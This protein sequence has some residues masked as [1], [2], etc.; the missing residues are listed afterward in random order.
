MPDYPYLRGASPRDR[1]LYRFSGL[2]RR[3]R[4]P[5]GA[6][7]EGAG[8][9]P[10]GFP[11]LQAARPPRRIQTLTGATDLIAACGGL[12]WIADGV[13]YWNGVS[14]GGVS[15][16]RHQLAA[17]GSRIVIFPDKL[18]LDTAQSGTLQ[19][20]EAKYSGKIVFTSDSMTLDSPPPF[21]V[22]DG[23]TVS[24]C[25]ALAENQKTVVVREIHGNTLVCA[26]DCFTAGTASG[27]TVQRQVPAL[28]F[29]CEKDNRLW[30]VWENRICCSV[31]GD[32]CNWNVFEGLAGDGW[33]T[34]VGT[35]G[36][37]TGCAAAASHVLFFKEDCVHKVYGV[38]PS[39]FQVQVSRIPGVQAGCERSIVNVG[40]I[41]YW[42]AR[43]GLMAYGGGIPDR[44]S[45]PLGTA[46]WEQVCAGAVGHTLYLSGLRDGQPDMTALQ[47]ESGAFA[48][49]CAVCALALGAQAG[50]F[51]YLTGD[52]LWQLDGG[53]RADSCWQA[54]LGPFAQPDGTRYK[55]SRLALVAELDAGAALTAEWQADDGDWT[56][57][58]SGYGRP[59]GHIRIP[60]PLTR[61]RRAALRLTGRGGAAVR[62]IVRRTLPDGED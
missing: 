24:G 26:A 17:I 50:D 56:P 58:W 35:G 1:V 40:E 47:L 46:A 28:R 6:L 44:L 36:A 9:D 32:P 57:F 23:V 27:A 16:G 2:D 53:T 13:F 51:Y 39:N 8:I 52:G 3:E 41:V 29:V 43:D 18:Y 4:A 33:Q 61:S 19:R 37:F 30:G 22:G 15:P 7:R 5:E 59:D 11:A 12:G 48:P 38:K 55:T 25:P 49:C 34:E 60:L 45:A 10:E 42:W 31:L 14:R 21:A 20:M 62:A 54:V